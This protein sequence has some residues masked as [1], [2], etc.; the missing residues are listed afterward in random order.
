MNAGDI[1]LPKAD[2][3]LIGIESSRLCV[4]WHMAREASHVPALFR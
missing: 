3:E 2:F 1:V 4:D